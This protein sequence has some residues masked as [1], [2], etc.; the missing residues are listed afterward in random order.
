V[1]IVIRPGRFV[2]EVHPVGKLA[3]TMLSVTVASMGDPA[4]F[5]RGRTLQ[6]EGAVQRLEIDAG[7]LRASVVGSRPEPYSV[8]ISAPTIPRPT[9]PVGDS[10]GVAR[11]M[12]AGL[13][14]DKSDVLTSCSCPDF[15]DPCKH[16][17]AALLAFAEQLTSQPRL[18]IEWRCHGTDG[19]R[20]EVGSRRLRDT[21]DRHLRL[22]APPNTAASI[23]PRPDSTG[24]GRRPMARTPEQQ[25][26]EH[27]DWL[28]FVGAVGIE[29]LEIP[30][31]PSE[32]ASVGN[33]AMGT[34]DLGGWVRSALEQLRRDD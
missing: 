9:G 21:T 13:L 30:D 7:T 24:P 31:V 3:S 32:A 16:S 19:Q 18:L 14:P 2:G 34:I 4:R 29:P 6:L 8:V 11:S 22:A 23:A 15:D 33:A 1:S 10:S 27:P 26:M 20:A 28:R 25:A 5:R 17:V 12:I